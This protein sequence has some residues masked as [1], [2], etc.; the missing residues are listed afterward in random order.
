MKRLPVM[1]IAHLFVLERQ[2]MHFCI[3]LEVTAH[4]DRKDEIHHAACLESLNK[5]VL[6]VLLHDGTQTHTR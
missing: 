2:A 3:A 1:I 5:L 6:I 4:V